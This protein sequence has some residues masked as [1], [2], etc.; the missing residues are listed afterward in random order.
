LEAWGECLNVKKNTDKGE[1]I[2]NSRS[3]GGGGGPDTGRPS[4]RNDVTE[5][6]LKP[7]IGR[8]RTLEKE[9]LRLTVT[10]TIVFQPFL[11]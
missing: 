4:S 5:K 9:A 8:V 2:E 3:G 7:E 6:R 1:N 11:L 10:G